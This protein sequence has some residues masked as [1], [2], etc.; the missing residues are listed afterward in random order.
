MQQSNKY[1][2]LRNKCIQYAKEHTGFVLI[3][4]LLS[5]TLVAGAWL[6]ARPIGGGVVLERAHQFGSTAQEFTSTHQN[7]GSHEEEPKLTQEL[8]VDVSGAVHSPGVVHLGEGS[9]VAD[10]ITAAGGVR[11][12]AALDAINQAAPVVDGSKV[13]VP[14]I[15][16][17]TAGTTSKLSKGESAPEQ[18]NTS[19]GSSHININQA[20]R[21]QLLSL[22]GVGPNTADA[23][24]QN[25]ETY[26]PFKNVDDLMRVPGIGK[27][28]FE[29]LKDSITI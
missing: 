29:K 5:M 1:L 13:V 7:L 15:Q 11:D 18:T 10:A 26:G 2:R 21:D 16:D 8:V 12:D 3:L 19:A 4:A 9:R 17:S 27:K 14:T 25:R 23:I 28:K 6:L 20:N 22:P 24:V